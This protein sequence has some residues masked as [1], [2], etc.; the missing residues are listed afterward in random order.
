MY[1]PPKYTPYIPSIAPRFLAGICRAMPT[2]KKRGRVGFPTPFSGSVTRYMN[3]KN[4]LPVLPCLPAARAVWRP[5]CRRKGSQCSPCA[6]RGRFVCAP[7][8]RRFCALCAPK[9]APA[10]LVCAPTARRCSGGQS[11]RRTNVRIYTL[12]VP[13]AT[14]KPSSWLALSSEPLPPI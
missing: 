5:C 6:P 3:D 9:K 7:T 1:L 13:P 8:A 14:C 10:G 4:G 12:Y 2:A 11:R